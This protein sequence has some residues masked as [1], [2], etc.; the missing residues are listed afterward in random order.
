MLFTIHFHLYQKLYITLKSS[1]AYKRPYLQNCPR[2]FQKFRAAD[3]NNHD[4]II[5]LMSG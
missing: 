4:I 2:Y 5:F 1:S 3:K